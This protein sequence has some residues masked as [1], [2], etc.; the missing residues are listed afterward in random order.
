M[1]IIYP[2][3]QGFGTPQQIDIYIFKQFSQ[4]KN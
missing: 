1:H 3:L 2:L 4:T